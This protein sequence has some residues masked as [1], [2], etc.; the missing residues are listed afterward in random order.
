MT[1]VTNEI[2]PFGGIV[3]ETLAVTSA[4]RRSRAISFDDNGDGVI[5]RIRTGHV[6][7]RAWQRKHRADKR[8]I[9]AGATPRNRRFQQALAR[10]CVAQCKIAVWDKK[11]L[12]MLTQCHPHLEEY[13]A[14]ERER[15]A[16]HRG[17]ADHDLRDAD[18]GFGVLGS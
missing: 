18:A 13:D 9:S 15:S 10:R 7:P 1:D 12:Y 4:D 3:S 17:V 14:Y 6:L 8:H 11:N 5:D 16:W 2:A